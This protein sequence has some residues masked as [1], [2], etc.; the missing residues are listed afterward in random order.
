MRYSELTQQAKEN[1]LVEYCKLFNITHDDTINK[2]RGNNMV[3]DWFNKYNH[4]IFTNSGI[5]THNKR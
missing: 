1:A 4:D 3:V 5:L 2:A